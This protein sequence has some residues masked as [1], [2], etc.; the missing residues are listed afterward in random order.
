[1]G[2]TLKRKLE[3]E[4][5]V[6]RVRIDGAAKI[7]QQKY[8]LKLAVMVERGETREQIEEWLRSDAG[9]QEWDALKNEVKR[10]VG[11]TISRIADL[12]YMVGFAHGR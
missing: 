9:R 8:K 2:N 6:L 4:L 10:E 3:S 5:D 7:M 12:G 1:M 11:N